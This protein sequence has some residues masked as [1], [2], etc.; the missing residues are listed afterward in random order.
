MKILVAKKIGFTGTK[1][2]TTRK[3]HAA[4]YEVIQSLLPD[5][6]HHG[7]CVGADEEAHKVVCEVMLVR[8][9]HIFLHPP[10]D[11]KFRAYCGQ[12]EL[13][14]GCSLTELPALDYLHRNKRIVMRCPNYLI[15]CPAQVQEQLR[16]GTWA[17]IR[18]ARQR[19]VKHRYI[20]EPSGK[21]KEE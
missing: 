5:E 13:P 4:L 1:E 15:A 18:Y 8:P 16:S 21:V 12:W 17:T 3:Q 7:D 2:G 9:G 11:T 10:L 14:A 20:I 6:F 19:E